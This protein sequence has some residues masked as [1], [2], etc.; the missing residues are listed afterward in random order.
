MGVAGEYR[1]A[2]ILTLINALG[3]ACVLA[4]LVGAA[5]LVRRQN[6]FFPP[7]THVV[8]PE[9]RSPGKMRWLGCTRGWGGGHG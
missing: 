1:L 6:R 9:D 3:I 4:V 5:W 8:D 2:V 7:G